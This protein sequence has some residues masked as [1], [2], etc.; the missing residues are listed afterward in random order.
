MKMRFVRILVSFLILCSCQ[1]ESFEV[2]TEYGQYFASLEQFSGITKAELNQ[3]TDIVWSEG[4]K[5]VVFAGTNN[6]RVF[7]V[8]SSSV[9]E[10]SGEFA[11]LDGYEIRGSC[12]RLDGTVGV[13]PYNNIAIKTSENRG[14]VI[15]GILFPTEQMYSEISFA[16]DSCPMV[17][18]ISNDSNKLFF[19]NVGGILKLM[20][21]GKY[22]VS[23]ITLRGNNSEK[24]SGTAS[25]ILDSKGT[26]SVQMDENASGDVS[27]ICLPAVELNP[28]N[29]TP[30]YI[31][32]PPTN[33]KSGYIITIIDE[34]GNEYVK[35]IEGENTIGRSTVVPVSEV[36][37]TPSPTSCETGAANDISTKSAVIS[38]VFHNVPKGSECGVILKWEKGE[39][40][41]PAVARNGT[42]DIKVEALEPDVSYTYWAYVESEGNIISGQ[43]HE[44]VTKAMN[45]VDMWTCVETRLNGSKEAYTIKLFDDGTALLDKFSNYD[46]A[47]W[48]TNGKTL[49]V[50][51]SSSSTYTYNYMKLV[52]DMSDTEDAVYG[53]GKAN[54]GS[55]NSYSGNGSDK[56]YDLAMTRN[57]DM[58]STHEVVNVGVTSA[59]VLCSY[60]N[61]PV[62]GECGVA[63]L[64]GDE[65]TLYLASGIDGNQEIQIS[66]IEPGTTY[67][68]WSYVRFDD[69]YIMGNIKEFTTESMRVLGTWTCVETYSNGK[70]QSWS[71]TLN[72]DGTVGTD[73]TYSDFSGS[74][75]TEGRELVVSFSRYTD[76]SGSGATLKVSIDTPENPISGTGEAIVWAENWN[77]GGSSKSYR[78]LVM[79]RNL[80]VCES[81]QVNV[82][83]EISAVITCVYNNVPTG[84]KCGL[85]LS[86]NGK[87]LVFYSS[88]LDGTQ[89]ID[90]VGLDPNTT[91]KYWAFVEYNG[92]YVKGEVK[93]VVTKAM[94]VVGTWLCVETYSN[95]K[96]ESYSVDLNESGTVTIYRSNYDYETAGWSCKAK[97]LHIGISLFAASPSTF[98][99]DT[100]MIQIDDPCN[101]RSGVGTTRHE[102]IDLNTLG[103]SESIRDIRMIKQ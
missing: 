57:R 91:Y 66:N 59:S 68:Y 31:S 54:Y 21:E 10:T 49:N 52:V 76:S 9:G 14:Y 28:T 37:A 83:T 55:Y 58:C 93:E 12:S 17:A 87:E 16:D 64:C 78:N 42:Q 11:L 94:D 50:T 46:H 36:S 19:K 38:C 39:L 18:M 7:E 22:A 60:N 45:L 70:T 6:G 26:S 95:G 27:L 86:S 1:R 53:V 43:K 71:V 61:V 34:D 73:G 96:T 8:S 35:E 2:Q 13:Y 89:M 33:F 20:L 88:V 44:F 97:E 5:I 98:I 69:K 67:P 72:A 30:F 48:T 92:Y 90:A 3:K 74:W 47:V 4:D 81:G 25:I 84:S 15:S 41:C 40:I 23:R 100:I 99:S 65:E 77:T 56:Y 101:P 79:T 82:V 51:F 24:L 29:A 75:K 102:I 32:L 63:I 103:S 62:G 80:G 85:T